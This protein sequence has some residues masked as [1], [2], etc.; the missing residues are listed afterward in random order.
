MMIPIRLP[1]A[2]R[3]LAEFCGALWFELF[4]WP[5]DNNLNY[6]DRNFKNSRSYFFS[7]WEYAAGFKITFD[8]ETRTCP[9]II[10]ARYTAGP[11]PSHPIRARGTH[12]PVGNPCRCARMGT[13]ARSTRNKKATRN[14]G[15]SSML[16]EDSISDEK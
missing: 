10:R 9:K 1:Q 15:T 6:R 3:G 16:N 7:L 11:V 8:L 12:P 4:G 13:L 2:S 5:T 14:F